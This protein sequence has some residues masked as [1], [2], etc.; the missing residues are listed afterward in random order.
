MDVPRRIFREYDIRGVIGEDL[1]AG[2]YSQLGAAIGSRFLEDGAK[3]GIVGYD[4]R[5][6]SPEMHAAFVTGMCSTGLDVLSIGE[7]PTPVLYYAQAVLGEGRNFGA[8]ITA[9]H[10]PPEY[11]GVKI[12]SAGRALSG[13]EIGELYERLNRELPKGEGAYREESFTEAYL[14]CLLKDLKP[15]RRVKVAVDCGNGTAGLV[16]RRLFEGWNTD[17]EILF[18]EPDGT[19]PNH[20]ADPVVAK[21]LVDLIETV[22]SGGYEFGIGFDGDSD[23]VGVIDEKGNILWGDRLLALFARHVLAEHPGASVIFE[24]KC[25][26]ALGEDIA[27]HGGNPILWKTGHSLIKAKM[28]EEKALLAGEMSGHLFFADRYYGYDDAL[29]A[30]GRLLEIVAKSDKPMSE[31]LADAPTYVATPEIRISCADEVKFDVVATLR[32][33]FAQEYDVIDIDGV[34]VEFPDGW[35]LVR[36]SNTGPVLVLRFEAKTQERVEEIRDLIMG[37]VKELVP[38]EG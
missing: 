22:K 33:R 36:A 21:N 18:E 9:S 15:A 17:C 3:E 27:A 38:E 11:N 28:K 37:A 26:R 29:Y 23:R 35:G 12:V 8:M 6:H 24:V 13:D 20:P 4:N 32:D 31:L 5:T 2:I 14:E 30:A 1:D 25:S 7:V 16:A 10:N 34:R 19:F